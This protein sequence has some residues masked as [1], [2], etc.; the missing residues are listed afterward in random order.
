MIE[1]KIL[2]RRNPFLIFI[3]RFIPV[4]FTGSI[5]SFLLYL[6]NASAAKALC[7]LFFTIA[8][9][10]GIK[11]LQ[12]NNKYLVFKNGELTIYQG[13]TVTTISKKDIK[14]IK[15]F[16]LFKIIIIELLNSNN[17][18]VVNFH[19]VKN[20]GAKL[21]FLVKANLY[22]SFPDKAKDFED[23]Y[24]KMYSDSGDIPESV[25]NIDEIGKTQTI[26]FAI[27]AI[28]FGII[29]I[30]FSYVSLLWLISALMTILSSGIFSSLNGV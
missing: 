3:L 26:I 7:C 25:K 13:K 27:I 15:E 19:L 5:F 17:V 20:L 12:N 6:H 28:V 18:E 2:L 22:T 14:K 9:I 23:E 21:Y 10:I 4:I 11:S 8:I 1:R 29:P 24:V 16:P 30:G